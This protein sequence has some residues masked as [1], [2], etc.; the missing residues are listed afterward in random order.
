[1][2]ARQIL[3]IGIAYESVRGGVAA[4]ENVYSTFYKPF[5][6]IA[7]VGSGDDSKI[8]GD[9]VYIGSHVSIQ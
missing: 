5:N 4:V 6:H 2:D 1:M 3:T 9:N 7:T 8:I